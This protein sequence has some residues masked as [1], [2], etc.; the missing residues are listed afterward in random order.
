MTCPALRT[1]AQLPAEAICSKKLSN[2]SPRGLR[3]HVLT[4]ASVLLPQRA[5]RAAEAD[6]AAT[7]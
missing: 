6:T 5:M 7:N 1:G 3:S 4:A 2:L